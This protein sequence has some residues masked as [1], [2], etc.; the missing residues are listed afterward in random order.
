MRNQW[1][2]IE[3]S[4]IILGI[5][6]AAATLYF[7]AGT[8]YRW[9][10]QNIA[11]PS[12]AGGAIMTMSQ[13]WM[14]IISGV[15]GFLLL[16]TGWIM[17]GLRQQSLMKMPQA[18]ATSVRLQFHPN[19]IIPTCL[20]MQNIFYWYALC[21]MFNIQ[22]GPSKQYEQGRILQTKQ[23]IIFLMFDTPV[24]LKQI[25]VDGHG[26]QLPLVEVKDRGVR[27]AIIVIS[28]DVGGALLDINVIV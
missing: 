4:C 9:N 7:T 6:I 17:I 5:F 3:R 26:A 1:Q 2:I 10:E 21:T 25:V 27:H 11:S 22:E 15:I 28:G 19:S 18:I 14:L 23:W 8:Y 16:I 24:E 13:W 20:N 12:F